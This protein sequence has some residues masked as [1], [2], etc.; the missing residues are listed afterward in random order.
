MRI[1]TLRFSPHHVG[2]CPWFA[3]SVLGGCMTSISSNDIVC[4]DYARKLIRFKARQLSRQLGFG[5]AD[6]EDLRQDLLLHLLSQAKHFNP[7][8]ASLNTFI[9]RVV[10]SGI[11]LILRNRKCPFPCID[12]EILSLESTMQEIEGDSIS[13]R[14]TIHPDDLSRRTGFYPVSETAR[15]EDA[16][17]INHAMEPLSPEMKEI[18]CSLMHGSAHAAAR[19]MN[20]SRRQIRRALRILHCYFEEAGF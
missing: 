12:E 2:G 15:K 7:Q 19:E 14:Q 1:A 4:A 16:E 3:A 8:R 5:P 13:M 20:M 18:C 6:E 11:A 9:N 10:S 17:A